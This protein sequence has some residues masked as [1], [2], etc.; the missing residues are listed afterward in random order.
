M[1]LKGVK[2][3]EEKELSKALDDCKKLDALKYLIKIENMTELD[4]FNVSVSI[5]KLS[6]PVTELK[7]SDF[8]PYKDIGLISEVYK[9]L[10]ASKALLEGEKDIKAA[11]S[12]KVSNFIFNILL[13]ALL[14]VNQPLE[15]SILKTS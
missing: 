6:L 2:E 4:I 13:L 10:F 9:A 14:L 3:I 11:N 1:T 7:P 5:T 12:K 8:R 15:K